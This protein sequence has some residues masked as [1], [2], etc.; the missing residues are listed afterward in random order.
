MLTQRAA[1]WWL[2]GVLVAMTAAYLTYERFGVAA[3]AIS[4]EPEGALVRVDGR[5][6]GVTPLRPLRLSPGFHLVEL[7]HSFYQ[8]FER[9]LNL[10]AG[11]PTEMH[12]VMQLGEGTLLVFSN[13]RG[14]WVEV[15]GERRE[16]VTPLALQLP[17]G[18]REVVMGMEERRSAVERVV[19]HAGQ[20]H[21]LRLDLDINPHGSLLVETRP[22]GA[23]ISLPDD[24]TAYEPGVR[25]R[26]G[27]YRVRIQKPGYVTQ[28]IRYQV[29]YGDN[30]YRVDLARAYGS[31]TI[32]GLPSGARVRVAYRQSPETSLVRADYEPGMRL[33]VGE[34]EVRASAMG[35]RSAYRRIDLSESGAALALALEPMNVVP[36]SRLRDR[37]AAGGQGPALVVIPP[38][39]FIMGSDDGPPSERPARRV[40][41]TEPFAVGVYEVRVD[42]YRRF[43]TATGRALDARLVEA[44]AALPVTLVRAADAAAYADWLTEQTGHRY[45][46]LSEA[47]W[48][49][50]ARAGSTSNYAFGDAAAD[51]CRYANV[52]DLSIP[53]R[54]VGMAVVACDD[55]FPQLAPVGS[56]LANGF[57]VHD[58][59]GNVAEWVLECGMPE[60]AGAPDDGSPARDGGHCPTHGVRGGSWDG[61]ADDA[62]SAKRAV[63]ASPSGARGIRLLREL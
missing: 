13:P 15:D 40:V 63:A 47:E 58:M 41:L 21:E 43:A 11:A 60:Y 27:E 45:R 7:S 44:D 3:L 36:G 20:R 54:P 9:R 35:R 62:R 46:L 50:V 14:A 51:L 19:V 10:G 30:R 34:V 24:D 12:V 59:H 39:E 29:R 8:P 31:L 48:E 61:S 18:E 26:V 1:R 32:A 16:G 56:F 17:S 4:S 5:A 42:E 55:G 23:R 6:I 53:R 25:L 57:G 38:G 49:Y 33:P 52:A 37:L 22:E 28:D 2:L